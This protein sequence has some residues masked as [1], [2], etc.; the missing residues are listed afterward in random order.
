VKITISAPRCWRAA[1]PRK[2][3]GVGSPAYM[4]PEQVKDHPLDHR[5]DIYSMA[6]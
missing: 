6:W 5:T 1:I 3:A 2:V 4:S